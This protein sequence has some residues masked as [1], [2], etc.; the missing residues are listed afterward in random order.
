MPYMDGLELK[1]LTKINKRYKDIPVIVYT[2]HSKDILHNSYA[3]K[4]KKVD[5]ITVINKQ[6]TTDLINYIKN[7][8]KGEYK[9]L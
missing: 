6:N 5:E 7:K 3:S 2:A 8:I 9:C 4:Y 1:V